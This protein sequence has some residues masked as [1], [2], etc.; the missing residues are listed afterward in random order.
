MSDLTQEA[1]TIIKELSLLEMLRRYGD[2]RLVGSVPLD[3]IVKLDIDIH[4]LVSN[5]DLLNTVDSI[6]HRLLENEQIREVRISDYRPDGVKISVD[7]YPGTS[8]DWSIDIWIT[9]QVE[10]T[11]FS[12]VEHIQREL[13]PVHRSAIMDIKRSYHDQGLLRDGISMR[14]YQAVLDYGVRSV[15]AFHHFLDEQNQEGENF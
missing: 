15:K 12:F 6:Y 13:L 9:S 4:V 7:S 5:R 8:G 1:H 14:I 10:T 2:A 11:G 3:L